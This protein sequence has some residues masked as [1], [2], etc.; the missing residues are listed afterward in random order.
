MIL[1]TFRIILLLTF[2]LLRKQHY[3]IAQNKHRQVKNQHRKHILNILLILQPALSLL[4][5]ARII[6]G[7]PLESSMFA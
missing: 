7:M 3:Q 6:K 1:Y 2:K 4:I 5:L